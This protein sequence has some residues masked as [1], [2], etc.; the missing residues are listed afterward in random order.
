[1]GGPTSAGE[2]L[3]EDL[4]RAAPPALSSARRRLERRRPR[5]SE[6][7]RIREERETPDFFFCPTSNRPNQHSAKQRAVGPV[8]AQRA[9][10]A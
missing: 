10:K 9:R 5:E 6:R 1:M 7:E 2:A 4:A 3:D 8:W